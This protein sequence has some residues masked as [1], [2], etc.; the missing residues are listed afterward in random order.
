MDVFYPAPVP[1][2]PPQIVAR[3]TNV[4]GRLRDG[5]DARAAEAEL[6]TLVPTLS[7]NSGHCS[8]SCCAIT[9]VIVESL[10]TATVAPVRAQ[11]VLLGVLVAVVLLIATTNVV[12]LFL[13]R[14]ERASSEIAIA[15]SLGA[16][17]VALAQRFVVEGI[18]LGLASAVVALPAAA[19]AV[20]TKFGFTEREI[21]RLHEVSFTWQTAALVLGCSVLISGARVGLIAL[22]RA[23]GLRRCSAVSAG[24]ARHQLAAGA[25]GRPVSS[26]FRSRSHSCCSS[27]SC[28]LGRS[29][30]NLRNANLGFDPANA[31]T[32]QVSLPWTGYL[33]HRRCGLPQG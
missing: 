19:L 31:M 3:G 24:R 7:V 12:N 9:R 22:T 26:P 14:A 4:I 5:V 1:L 18:A 20:S 25:A 15:L 6:N 21:P 10:K 32:F 33:V 29:F 13:L 8:L 2:K 11:L 16:S 17:R 27:P 30:W 23:S 28:L